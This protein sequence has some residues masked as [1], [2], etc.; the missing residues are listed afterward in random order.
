MLRERDF[1]GLQRVHR[2][3][4]SAALYWTSSA[5]AINA[6][7]IPKTVRLDYRDSSAGLAKRCQHLEARMV[8]WLADREKAD[9]PIVLDGKIGWLIKVYLTHPYSPFHEKRQKTQQRYQY[10]L[11]ELNRAVGEGRLSQLN[12]IDFRRWYQM[13]KQ[14]KHE[15]GRDRIS[16]AHHL[17]NMLRTVL[18]FGNELGLPH[19][20]RLRDALSAIKF[21]DAPARSGRP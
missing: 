8:A 2:K 21:P 11:K 18:S 14:P 4:G 12:G 9:Q 10:Y 15:D 19:A 7:F 20:R 16:G 17:M 5:A 1:P 13:F 3:D 6:G